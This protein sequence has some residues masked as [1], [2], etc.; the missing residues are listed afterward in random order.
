MH[1]SI[2]Q[3]APADV[4][5][6]L[7]GIETG[8][9]RELTARVRIL[10][11]GS[12]D[13]DGLPRVIAELPDATEAEATM[14]EAAFASA[15]ASEFDLMYDRALPARYAITDDTPDVM[16]EGLLGMD[17]T[18]TAPAGVEVINLL[19]RLI[20][21]PVR[22]TG[23]ADFP[24]DA[25]TGAHKK[26]YS[27][28]VKTLGV[29]PNAD[30]NRTVTEARL[31]A[32]KKPIGVKRA[33]WDEVIAHLS[34]EV[35]FFALAD[36]W[37]GPTG[38]WHGVYADVTT[39]N[40]LF[41]DTVV[42]NYKLELQPDAT[43]T[44]LLDKA[45]AMTIGVI[46]GIP[47]GGAVLAEIAALLWSAAKARAGNGKVQG[48]VARIKAGIAPYYDETL[49]ALGATHKTTCASWAALSEFG[50]RVEAKEI[51]W[52]H[53]GTELIRPHSYG[54]Q[55]EALRTLLAVASSANSEMPFKVWGIAKQMKH[56]KTQR[57]KADFDPKTKR[58]RTAGRT[59]CVGNPEYDE[60]FI[61]LYR[62]PPTGSG[63]HT[64]QFTELSEKL[65]GTGTKASNP[66]LALPPEFLVKPDLR[67]KL[68][69]E[70][71]N[72]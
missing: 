70:I 31:Y 21:P 34:Q 20:A 14:I 18:N 71:E 67:K 24:E 6:Y 52:P 51:V 15:G 53:D 43:V 45:M 58:W 66:D 59:R 33:V 37:W 47:E 7:R 39:F 36:K 60:V 8:L 61:G 40:L 41:I 26:A 13:G 17:A 10:D 49:N 68:K 63:V 22:G 12:D 48:E 62:H 28:I 27:H 16:P 4:I 29:A 72:A 1:L 9:P 3:S 55:Y 44:L 11:I 69:W 64:E 32:I 30:P 65:F 25:Y 23:G 19:T 46:K 50:A 57:K 2:L 38:L 5:A 42:A 35:R 56:S 54:F